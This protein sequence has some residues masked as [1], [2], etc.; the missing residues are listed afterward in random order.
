[1]SS[2]KNLKIPGKKI[3]VWPQWLT[4][5][6]ISLETIVSGLA[7]GWASPYLAQL[8]SAEADVSLKMT[9]IEASWMASLLSFGRVIGA[10]IGAF[11]QVYW[12]CLQISF[13]VSIASL[14][15][16][17]GNVMGP[18]LS[19]EMFAYV[20]LVPNVL[21]MILFSLIPESPY[22]YVLHGNIDKAEASLKWFQ[23]EA[24]MKA[25]MQEFQDFVN[26]ANTS[27]LTKFKDFLLPVNLKNILILF[28]LNLFVQTSSFTTINAYAE[29]IVINAKVNITPSI[30]VMALCFS[31][32]VA[33][34]IAI[35]VVDK[36][37]RKN[38]L[39]LS[40]IGVTISYLAL[41][42]HFY[43]LSLNFDPE[44]LTWLPITSLLSFNL[45]VSYGLATVP[46]T[47]LG[48]MFPA[49]LKNLASLCIFST[50]ALLTFVF[51]KCFQPF[52][53]LTGETIVFW[54][55]GLFVLG[56][57]PYVMYLIPETTGKSL[58]EIQQS[59]KNKL[60]DLSKSKL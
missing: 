53:N 50:N 31:T 4:A 41:G 14:G 21:F 5:L 15:M 60:Y 45:F 25:K 56:A 11:C 57:V 22:H 8:I 54:S 23:R 7:N 49:N 37:G 10:F 18:Y 59:I 13:N 20:S 2:I 43:L 17:L 30:V 58:L 16:F 55:Y 42:L 48:E 26:G 51:V 28:G 46:S 34:F 6:A 3:T 39:I 35:F 29:I 9:D 52:V 44:K 24:D 27:I 47:L 1:M 36:F 19:M 40:S 32:V 12:L 33:G 38:L